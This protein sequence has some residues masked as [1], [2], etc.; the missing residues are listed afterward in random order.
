MHRHVSGWR[1]GVAV[2]AGIFAKTDHRDLGRD[3]HERLRDVRDLRHE[4][5]GLHRNGHARRVA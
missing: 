4:R 1:T 3:V 2:L 5:H